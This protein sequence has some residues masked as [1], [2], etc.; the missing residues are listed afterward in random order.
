MKSGSFRLMFLFINP[1]LCLWTGASNTWCSHAQV[2]HLSSITWLMGRKSRVITPFLGKGRVD[3]SVLGAWLLLH[4][5]FFGF[6]DKQKGFKSVSQYMELQQWSDVGE[7]REVK[8][9]SFSYILDQL[10][11][12]D[13][14]YGKKLNHQKD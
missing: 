13:C 7:V 2:S 12:S 8:N 1:S 11:K 4:K 9:K 10:Q 3:I 6:V 14:T 5:H